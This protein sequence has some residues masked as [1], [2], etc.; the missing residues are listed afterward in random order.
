MRFDVRKDILKWKESSG[1][2]YEQI[3][4]P[5]GFNNRKTCFSFLHSKKF[6]RYEDLMQRFEALKAALES[7][8]GGAE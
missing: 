2:S 3:Y 1:L 4:K 8:K 6:N 5:L 7:E